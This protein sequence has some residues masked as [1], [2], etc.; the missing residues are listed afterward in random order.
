MSRGFFKRPYTPHVW[1]TVSKDDS[2]P[3]PQ[4]VPLSRDEWARAQYRAMSRAGGTRQQFDQRYLHS[5]MVVMDAHVDQIFWQMVRHE[6]RTNPQFV[7]HLEFISNFYEVPQHEFLERL[8]KRHW[9]QMQVWTD[10]RHHLK[11]RTEVFRAWRAAKEQI[12]DDDPANDVRHQLERDAE[13]AA[14]LS[15][16]DRIADMWH[17]P[18]DLEMAQ[19]LQEL[20]Q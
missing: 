19:W 20:A 7:Q 5:D 4:A 10:D 2:P 6:I 8:K 17:D 16:A 11:F 9:A 12:W 15:H 1:G 13:H 3:V 18:S 14:L